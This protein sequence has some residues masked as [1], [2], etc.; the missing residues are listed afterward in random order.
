M[1]TKRRIRWHSIRVWH[2]PYCGGA[3]LPQLT[4]GLG[5]EASTTLWTREARGRANPAGDCSG[6]DD[7]EI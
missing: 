3:V 2:H 1:K 6:V 5:A 4:R 7:G